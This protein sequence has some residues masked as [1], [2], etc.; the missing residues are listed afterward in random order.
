M[1]VNEDNWDS[2]PSKF[3]GVE[4]LTVSKEFLT[5]TFKE[6]VLVAMD[7]SYVNGAVNSLKSVLVFLGS[8]DGRHADKQFFVDMISSMVNQLEKSQDTNEQ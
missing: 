5:K 7:E 4:T 6:E 8:V 3:C 2:Q 1:I